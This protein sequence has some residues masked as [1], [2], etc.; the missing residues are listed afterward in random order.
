MIGAVTFHLDYTVPIERLRSKALEI[1][2]AS[3]HWDGDVASMQVSDAKETSLEVKVLASARS[4][5]ALND[6]R[7]EIRE[8]MLAFL[9][10]EYPACLPRL[11]A[12]RAASEA[13]TPAATDA[14]PRRQI[15]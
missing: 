11:V 15:S 8:K 4:S 13:E 10:Q 1:V 14:R 12:P 5:G 6:L 7:S 9:Q 3:P 2:K